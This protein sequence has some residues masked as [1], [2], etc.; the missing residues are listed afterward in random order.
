MHFVYAA[1]GS[2]VDLSIAF[3]SPTA[4]NVPVSTGAGMNKLQQRIAQSRLKAQIPLDEV[5]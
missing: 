4:P 1:P 2:A 5:K 3:A